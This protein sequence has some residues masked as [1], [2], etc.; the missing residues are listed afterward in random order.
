[1]FPSPIFGLRAYA[2]L[3]F[4]NVS[5]DIEIPE[6]FELHQNYPNPF[7]PTTTIRF[8]L[9]EASRVNLVIYN[10]LGQKVITLQDQICSAGYKSV[11]WDGR[12]VGGREVA[13]G[14][15]FYR[16]EVNGMSSGKNFSQVKKMMML[17]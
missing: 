4:N 3:S 17:K 5:P 11:R 15:Y 14:L 16:L 6:T 7:N 10:I 1:V 13:S 2:L 12:S 8:D 9:P